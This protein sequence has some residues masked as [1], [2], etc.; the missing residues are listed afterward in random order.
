MIF[1]KPL[2]RIFT[3]M[4]GFVMPV[5]AH[6]QGDF[7]DQNAYAILHLTVPTAAIND[8]KRE[9]KKRYGTGFAVT[10]NGTIVTAL[11]V[12]EPWAAMGKKW[13]EQNPITAHRGTPDN[14]TSLKLDFV[15]QSQQQA[16][17]ALLE[18]LHE[19]PSADGESQVMPVCKPTLDDLNGMDV[20][21]A[22]YPS[23]GDLTP[24][25]TEVGLRLLNGRHELRDAAP[26]GVSGSPVYAES[27]R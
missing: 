24:Y 19:S 11:H 10:K 3:A 20:L 15:G 22:G 16:D 23:G 14:P 4:I 12:V 27:Y 18:I 26:G 9:I 2:F 5:M 7:V 8:G 21:I 1:R 17:L 6:A 13:R 25:S